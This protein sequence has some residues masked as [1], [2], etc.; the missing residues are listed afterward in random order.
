MVA[1]FSLQVAFCWLSFKCFLGLPA[2]SVPLLQ[3]AK[4]NP[5]W[6]TVLGKPDG[7]ASPLELCISAVCPLHYL[8]V[9][10]LVLP[11]HTH[12][13][14]QRLCMECFQLFDVVTVQGP[15][16]TALQQVCDHYHSK[17]FQF[18]GKRDG[19]MVEYPVPR[20]SR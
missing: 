1:S 5:S 2:L 20:S 15:S 13:R 19:V 12:N 6:E 16:F 11:L 14:P 3:L 4:E 9:G 10:D 8:Q 17:G 7:V 18:C